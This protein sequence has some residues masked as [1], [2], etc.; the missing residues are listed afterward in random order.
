MAP[1]TA[2]RRTAIDG[3]TTPHSGHRIIQRIRPRIEEPFGW[4]KTIAG[5][6]K[7]RYNGR[8]RN[9]ANSIGERFPMEW[10][11]LVVLNQWTQLA[12]SCSTSLRPVQLRR[13]S[14]SMSSVL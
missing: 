10:W 12:V 8:E 5:G 13:R 3:R 14:C 2:R 7:L 1:N 11:I 4:I 9:R 6:R